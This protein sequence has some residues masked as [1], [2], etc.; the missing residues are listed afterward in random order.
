MVRH[1]ARP[2]LGLQSGLPGRPP[3][4]RPPA[5]GLEDGVSACSDGS[6]S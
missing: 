6:D 1:R 4:I 5:S 3:L 2:Q